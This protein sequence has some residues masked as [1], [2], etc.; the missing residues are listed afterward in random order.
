[1]K[2]KLSLITII[3]GFGAFCAQAQTSDQELSQNISLATSNYALYPEPTQKLSKAP[4]GYKAFYMS[5]YGR[6]GSRYHYDAKDYANLYNIFAKADSAK[7]L[8]PLGKSVLE[9]F[10]QLNDRAAKKAGDLTQKGVAQHQGVA[11]RM[12]KNFPEIFKGDAYVEAMASTSV[13]C[14]VSMA[15]AL[16][17]LRALNPKMRIHQEASKS[18][19]YFLNPYNFESANEYANTKEWQAESAKMY[20]DI[21][22]YT[23]MK[24]LFTDS[25]WV[26][27]FMDVGTFYGKF[28]EIQSSMQ[29][30]DDFDFDFRDVWTDAD[31][32]ARWKA[33]NAWWYSVLGNCPLTGNKGI[34]FAKP[35]LKNFLDEADRVLAMD[36][37]ADKNAKKNQPKAT[38]RYGHDTGLLPL[39]GLMGLDVAKANT[40]DI[41]NLY[42][43][44]TD[45]RIVPMAANIQW[46]FYK[47]AKKGAPI[48]VKVLYNEN[49]VTLPVACGITDEAKAKKECP[50]APYYRWED[51]RA[52]Y[53]KIAE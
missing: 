19:V 30:L 34:T 1:M 38:L 25:A 20:K 22:P 46:I 41:E 42:K 40:S 53:L 45:F 16:E 23:M 32:I 47:S 10:K 5:H 36:S 8:T 29:N 52:T 28:Y 39:A 7:V 12:Y 17:E 24:K 27:K 48:L 51:V 15:S 50:A 26:D 11:N 37:S 33:Q 4:A 18:T 13:R 31:L 6:H 35:L 44:W 49:E 21:N 9:R 2:I 3:A 43:V 14:V